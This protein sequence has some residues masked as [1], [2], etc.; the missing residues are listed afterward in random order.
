MSF[1][2][3]VSY[4]GTSKKASCLQSALV[5]DLATSAATKFSLPSSTKAVLSHNGVNLDPSV[6]IKASKVYNNATLQLRV[7]AQNETVTAKVMASF[8]SSTTTKVIKVPSTNSPEMLVAK[9]L[10]VANHTLA[11]GERISFSSM[12]RNLSDTD[13]AF[14]TATI[15]DIFGT[16]SGVVRLRFESSGHNEKI[17]A[18]QAEQQILRDQFADAQREKRRHERELEERERLAQRGREKSSKNEAKL[19]GGDEDMAE[20]GAEESEE[21]ESEQVENKATLPIKTPLS[22]T[23]HSSQPK[24]PIPPIQ[25]PKETADTLYTQ[26]GASSAIYENPENDYNVTAGQAKLLLES[27]RT[28]RPIKKTAPAK[29]PD[30]YTIRLR[31]P[32]RALLDIHVSGTEKFGQLLKKI[33]SYVSQ[34]YINHYKLKSGSPPFSEVTM[35]FSENNTILNEHPAFLSDK[36]L[37]IWE[38]SITSLVPYVKDGL[39]KKDASELPNVYLESHRGQ[40]ADDE[41]E[42]NTPVKSEAKKKGPFKGA[43][44]WFRP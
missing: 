34:P 14:K 41:K 8:A 4:N 26:T 13:P 27:V 25:I 23:S 20:A 24:T 30:S 10:E 44:K 33:D 43:P 36:L 42:E 6:S 22:S 35:G 2:F 21:D 29:L 1:S 12:Q 19:P 5:G 17:R 9:F 16:S 37:L 31:F 15:G 3:N 38:T 40:L 7:I 18:L 11:P 28:V 32:D 39:V